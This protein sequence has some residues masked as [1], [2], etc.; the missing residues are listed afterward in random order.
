MLPRSRSIIAAALTVVL[1]AALSGA[2][3]PAAD[4]AKAGT[5]AGNLRGAKLPSTASGRVPI[6]AMRLSDGRVLGAAYAGHGGKFSLKLPRG[7]YALLAAIVKL[8]RKPPLV[9]VADL[10]SVKAGKRTK[11]PA[12]RRAQHR[13]PSTRR[14]QRGSTSTRRRSGSSASRSKPRIPIFESLRRV[15]PT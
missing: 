1:V 15:W 5:I 12:G 3:A 13:R 10:V 14:D 11:R 6:W 9:R 4:A 7:N 2:S 8:G